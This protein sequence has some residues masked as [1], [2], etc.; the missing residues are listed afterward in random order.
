MWHAPAMQ[1][2]PRYGSDPLLVLDGPPGAV[3]GPAIRQYRRLAAT[4]ASFTDEQWAHPSRCE[5]WSSRDVIAHLET[6]NNFWVL[7]ITAGLRGD[8]TRFLATFDPVATPAQLV[9]ATDGV[10]TAEVVERFLAGTESLVELLASLD[11]D[12]WRKPAEAPPGHLSID[13][14]VHHA[15]WDSWIHERDILLPQGTTPDEEADE[16]AA[17]L[18]YV[19]GL[20][21]AFAISNGTAHTGTLA[22]EAADPEVSFVVEV[23]DAVTVRSASADAIAGADV[24]LGGDAVDLLESLSIRRPLDQAVPA[25]SAWMLGGLA[26]V[27]TPASPTTG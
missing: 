9:A 3:A 2:T 5:G 20:G 17:A 8:P 27:F 18:R 23:D 4:V 22:A 15:F 26:D 19:A 1:L 7:S 10:P 12:D 13:A 25:A 6:A 14:L 21:P 16:I 24:R 11:G